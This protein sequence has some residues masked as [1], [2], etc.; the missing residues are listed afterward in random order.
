MEKLN[1]TI[2]QNE[3]IIKEVSG[4]KNQIII[5]LGRL[6]INKNKSVLRDNDLKKYNDLAIEIKMIKSTQ[7]KIA[8][9]KKR[10]AGIDSEEKNI[11]KKLKEISGDNEK[12]FIGIGETV[13][14]IYL[15][16]P[17]ELYELEDYLTEMINL[18]SK[19]TE[20]DEKIDDGE[21][22][23]DAESFFTKILSSGAGTV[24][25]SRKKL[26][27]NK[28]ITL[29]KAAG[30][31][32]CDEHYFE[33]VSDSE[34][35]GIFSAY[36]GNLKVVDDFKIKLE[37]L[38][39]E[40]ANYQSETDEK[41]D[42]LKT[43]IKGKTGEVIEHKINDQNSILLEAGSAFYQIF[44]E[45][46]DKIPEE[47]NDLTDILKLITAKDSRILEL[48]EETSSLKKE[49]KILSKQTEIDKIQET[50]QSKQEKVRILKKEVDKL[51]RTA[52]KLEN[53]IEKLK[54]K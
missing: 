12:H 3:K 1:K 23:K 7:D 44:L 49:V 54:T 38:K 41:E 4:E 2:K 33:K 16:R 18:K 6:L 39:A 47:D 25:E 42:K 14:S 15:E 13:F 19:I 37:S 43:S 22:K 11:A 29:Y 35:K 30:K 8:Q 34:I 27:E 20:L 5:D 28:Y 24:L 26:L 17:G 31:R 9:Y 21:R 52:K 53:E 50:V 45:N 51:N 40:K 32:L 48:T 10:I 46:S 36:E